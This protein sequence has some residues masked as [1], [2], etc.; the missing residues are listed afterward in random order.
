MFKMPVTPFFMSPGTC[1]IMNFSCCSS[2][3][4]FQQKCYPVFG[5]VFE[6][7]RNLVYRNIAMN[8]YTNYFAIYLSHTIIRKFEKM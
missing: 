3:K 4:G 7:R 2:Q 6:E 8:Y 1:N 5:N